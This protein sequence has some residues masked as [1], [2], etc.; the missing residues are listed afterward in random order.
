MYQIKSTYLKQLG[1]NPL[2]IAISKLMAGN[3][4]YKRIP[5]NSSIF[6]QNNISKL[7]KKALIDEKSIVLLLVDIGNMV[8]PIKVC[9]HA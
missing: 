2:W 8:I 4:Y 6:I 1:Q 3:F 7:N 9:D 5:H